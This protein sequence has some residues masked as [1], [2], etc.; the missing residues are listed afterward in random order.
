MSEAE[1]VAVR[2]EYEIS[3]Y[4]DLC[5]KRVGFGD[6]GEKN[7]GR[8]LKSKNHK[9]IEDALN[10]KSASSFANFFK[11]KPQTPASSPTPPVPGSS[12]PLIQPGFNTTPSGSQPANRRFTEGSDEMMVVPDQGAPVPTSDSQ[13][14]LF[15]VPSLLRRSQEAP[16][17]LLVL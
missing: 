14:I 10:S 12:A 11:S 16:R 17:T 2:R 9:K 4:C 5:K 7:W 13:F 6:G 3:R 8:H 15:T 1:K